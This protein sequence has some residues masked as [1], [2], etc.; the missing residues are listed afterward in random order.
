MTVEQR[1]IPMI[2]YENVAEAVRSLS[3]MFG[4]RENT[5]QRY[6]EK[7]GRVSHAELDLDGATVMLGT[8]GPDYQSPKHHR[9]ACE[10][11]RRW[12]QKPF[13]IDG[14][15]VQVRDINA[16]FKRAKDQGATILSDPVDEPYGFREYR[17]E[18]PEGHRWMFAQPI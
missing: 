17:A 3:R 2:S 12:S 6:T 15:F 18:D 13:I 5:E 4:F 1:A 9:S 8:P 14:V 16:H 11:A 7:D 10:P